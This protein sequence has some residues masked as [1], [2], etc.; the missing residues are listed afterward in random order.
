MVNN[1]THSPAKKSGGCL[2]TLGIIIL[3]VIITI[4]LSYWLMSYYLFPSS[5]KPVALN[6]KEESVLV[7]KLKQ[8][9]VQ[10]SASVSATES[11]SLKPEAYS[12]VG[13]KREVSFTERELNSL[14]AKNTDLANK[15]A[16]DLAKN[17]ISA[18]V[19][20]PLDEDFP[21]LG[22]K[23]LKASA[24]AYLSFEKGRP[25]VILKGVSVWGVPIPNAWL[26]DLKNV[27]L[28]KEFGADEG[29]WKSFAEG[30]EHI[31]VV[32]GRLQIKLKE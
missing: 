20:I 1:T 4:V 2:K 21:I 24:G 5:F 19:L 28:I 7:Q 29:F 18:R 6:N 16:I 26:G 12:E 11:E 17:L 25:I 9:G 27:D 15:V 32:E 8:L 31:E 3:T 13:A 23:M 14:I 10:A 22:G 30:V